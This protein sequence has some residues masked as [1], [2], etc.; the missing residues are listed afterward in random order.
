MGA[1]SCLKRARPATASSALPTTARSGRP[2]HPGRLN[3]TCHI[4]F[5]DADTP[6]R[7][8][9]AGIAAL[10]KSELFREGIDGEAL[11]WV[12][13]RFNQPTRDNHDLAAQSDATQRRLLF[14]FSDG[15]PMDSATHLAN[16]AHYLDHHL[17]DV[18]AHHEQA[19]VE[20]FGVGVDLDLSPYYRRSQVLDLEGGVGNAVLRDVVRMLGHAASLTSDFMNAGASRMKELPPHG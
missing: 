12:V 6:W 7:R 18:V 16:D 14:V 1:A 13:R 5:K 3:E 17:R 8:A 19:G 11:H 10:L 4:V 20:I 15:S 9:R 2:T